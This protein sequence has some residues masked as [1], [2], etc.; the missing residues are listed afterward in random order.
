MDHHVVDSYAMGLLTLEAFNGILPPQIGTSVPPQGKCPAA[1]YA[2]VRRM[3]VPNAKTRLPTAQVLESGEAD[4]EFFS[5]NKLVKVGK[6]M[7]NFMLSSDNERN[8]STKLLKENLK[9]FPAEFIQHKVIPILIQALNF[10]PNPQSLSSPTIQAPKILPLVLQL[11][12][13]LTDQDFKASLTPAIIKCFGS[14]DRIM[15]MALL[16]HLDLYANRLENKVVTDKIWPH[17]ITGF[18]DSAVQIREA[19]VKAI[20]PLAPKLSDRILNNDLLRQLA[21]TQVDPEP[22]IRTNTTIL[23]GR[24]SPQL[25]L[26]TRKKVLIPAFSR[27][28]KDPFV[29]AR[30]AGIMALMA[31][32][33]SYDKDDAA[34]QVL[35]AVVPSLVDGEKLVRDQASKAVTMFMKK[36]EEGVKD[37]PETLLPPEGGPV[38]AH[39]NAPPISNGEGGIVSSAGGAASALAGWAMSSAISQLSKSSNI[40]EIQNTSLDGRTTPGGSTISNP[41]VTNA[42]STSSTSNNNLRTSSPLSKSTSNFTESSSTTTTTTPSNPDWS[43]GGDLMDVMDDSDDWT[44]FSAAPSASTS[45]GRGIGSMR[46]GSARG[47]V[48]GRGSTTRAPSLGASRISSSASSTSLPK[49]SSTIPSTTSSI[50]SL[51]PEVQAAVEDEND[52][53]GDEWGVGKSDEPNGNSSKATTSSTNLPET[54]STSSSSRPSRAPSPSTNTSS[55]A[56][57][58]SSVPGWSTPTQG[59]STEDWGTFDEDDN[60]SNNSKVDT[61][62]AVGTPLSEVSAKPLT[63]EEKKAELERKREERKAVSTRRD[64]SRACLFFLKQQL[65]CVAS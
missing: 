15:R 1:L 65:L 55:T 38:G 13:N 24:L 44:G 17:L 8:H 34:K 57:A 10:V 6:G 32:G 9:S 22:G 25:S 30:V 50:S 60:N 29:H 7:D 2:L 47:S 51:A 56:D 37:M 19:T 39:P 4:G 27:S 62:S 20:L 31:T 42:T 26:N 33:D 59:G 64:W 40:A 63:R 36:V 49:T 54:T 21:K 14:A 52:A 16:D 46:R 61:G 23:L 48:R 58:F 11:G 3:M 35:P 12:T 53:W 43:R 18:V 45:S 5:E 41:N 28:L